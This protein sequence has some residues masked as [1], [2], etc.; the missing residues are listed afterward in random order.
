MSRYEPNATLLLHAEGTN[1]STVILDSSPG[2][3]A[4]TAVSTA[5]IST[6]QFK[7]GSSSLSLVGSGDYVS[8]TPAINLALTAGDFTVE[9]WIYQDLAQG[10]ATLLSTGSYPSGNGFQFRVLKAGG[11]WY[12]SFDHYGPYD[13]YGTPVVSGLTGW[14]HVAICRA[15][16]TYTAFFNG[17]PA[18][19]YVSTATDSNQVETLI[20]AGTYDHATVLNGCYLD[21]F[22]FTPGTARYTGA[23]T[24]ETAP[25]YCVIE[26][27]TAALTFPSL[28]VTGFCGANC[29]AAVPSLSALSYGGASAAPRLPLVAAVGH[30]GANAATSLSALTFKGLGHDSTGEW[31]ADVTLPALTLSAYGGAVASLTLPALALSVSATVT[32]W[33]HAD[34]TLPA[35]VATGSAT[36]GGVAS[37]DLTLPSPFTLIGYSGA[38]CSVTIGG[39]TTA[40]TGLTGS[41]A[42]AAVRL[43]LLDLTASGTAQNYGSADFLIP[44]LRSG[45]AAQAW[46]MLPGLTLTAIGTAVVSATY[47]AYAI[48]LKHNPRPGDNMLPI[49]EMTH[50]TN[51][52]FTHIV[53]YKNSYYGVNTT[54]LYLLEGTTDYAATPTAI[55]WSW[56]T[57][58]TDFGTATQKTVASAYFSGRLGQ[59]ST[60]TLS[61]GE[62][63]PL[64]Y[65]F[66]TPRD[67]LAQNHRQ[68][69][70]KGVKAR[71]YSLSASGAGICDVDG[72]ELD[73]RNL[74]RRI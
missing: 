44:A 62:Q 43:P 9:A 66:S 19:S 61:A 16:N 29:A 57:T 13:Y 2:G 37:A 65:S 28:T 55:P 12:V 64:S 23:F 42:S 22:M 14:I 18:G 72:V 31:A 21:E 17:T 67:A 20:G 34:V 11:D 46:L 25:F 8:V 45:N 27:A 36:V 32:N 1:A 50:Y 74:T 54:G 26:H 58:T 47:E 3:H 71:Y 60:I 73:V 24:P 4:L 49:D 39:L 52:P 53:R 38:V 51:F 35:L 5:Q 41:V 63:A 70:A 48:N 10:G 68:L 56:K 6:A 33:G 59:A 69:F 40:A 30:S 7:F 15:G